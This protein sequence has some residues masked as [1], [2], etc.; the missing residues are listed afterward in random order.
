MTEQDQITKDLFDTWL[1]DPITKHVFRLLQNLR[2]DIEAGLKSEA[3]ILDDRAQVKLARLLGQRESL[4]FMLN[5]EYGE[6]DT[7]V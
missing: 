3:I 7:D 4:D 5:M 6:E 2:E 1:R